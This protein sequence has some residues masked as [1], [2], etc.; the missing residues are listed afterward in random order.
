MD[1]PMPPMDDG[2]RAARELKAGIRRLRTLIRVTRRKLR[3][4]AEDRSFAP[5][6]DLG[7]PDEGEMTN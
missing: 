2:E 7:P 5:S 4:A 1:Q 3:R 6:D